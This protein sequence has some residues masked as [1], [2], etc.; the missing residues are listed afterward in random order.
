MVA[1]HTGLKLVALVQSRK[2]SNDDDGEMSVP[3][4][5]MYESHTSDTIG[6]LTDLLDKAQADLDVT[7]CAVTNTAHNFAMLK[8][9]LA[10]Q[11]VQVNKASV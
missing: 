4:A 5:A 6:V 9:S 8:Q 1:E 10:D 11:L 7:R 3:A 2:S